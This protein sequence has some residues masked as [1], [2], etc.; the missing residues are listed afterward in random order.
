MN[1]QDVHQDVQQIAKLVDDAKNATETSDYP[2]AAKHFGHACTLLE[3]SL[4]RLRCA[5]AQALLSA[6]LYDQVIT[7]SDLALRLSDTDPTAWYLKAS[8]LYHLRRYPLAKSAFNSAAAFESDLSVKTSYMDWASRCDNPVGDTDEPAVIPTAKS[9]NASGDREH[10]MATE[11]SSGSASSKPVDNTRLQWYQSN[12]HVNIDIFA[13][14][15]IRAESEVLFS[16]KCL[17]IRLHRPDVP[18]Y[19]M[20]TQ[21]AESI[22]AAQSTWSM[23]R[24]KVEIRLKKSVPAISWKTLDNEANVVSAA[25]EAKA[26]S[27]RRLD[28]TKARQRGWDK[29]TE[30]ELKDY[31]EDD[32]SM[33]L[34]KA[35]YQDADDDT[36]RAMSKSY[37]ESGGQVLSTDWAEVKKKKVVYEGSD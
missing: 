21:L 36:R 34:F 28:E 19:V 4:L 23:S 15:V 35:I 29:V 12:T 14:N 27:M 25:I 26:N 20:D 2:D 1:N 13:K 9:E 18:D 16:E 6:T 31:K 17:S 22:D 11:Q 3:K 7:V 10:L 32:S 30:S 24:F 5:Q 33:A 8:A 37:S